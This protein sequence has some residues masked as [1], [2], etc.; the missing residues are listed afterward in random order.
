MILLS[1]DFLEGAHYFMIYE[2]EFDLEFISQTN[3][4]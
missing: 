3:F 1:F 4:I 2:Q